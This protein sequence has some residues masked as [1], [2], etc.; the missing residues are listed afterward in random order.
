MKLW[1][2]IYL[3]TIGIF[4]ILLNSGIYL[5]FEMTYHKDI[6]SEQKSAASS[7]N[8]IATD[9]IRN[10]GELDRQG[11]LS[12]IQ[13]HS[14]LEIYENYYSEEAIGLTLW[15]GKTCIYPDEGFPVRAFEVTDTEEQ[16]KI[17][18]Q[19]GQKVIQV[20]GLLYENEE[21]YYLRYE[22]A[23]SEL[24]DTW[25][26]LEKRYLLISI[27]ASAGLAFL[28][29][30][31]L[32]RMMQPIQEL[33]EAVD[34]MSGGN[35]NSRIV[36]RGNDDIAILA[37]HFNE[38]AK[39]LQGDILLMQKEAQAKQMFVDNFAHELKSPLTS[40][41]GFA[42]YIQ[43][44]KVPEQEKTECMGFIMEESTR[45]LNL[46]YTLLD[47]AKMRK[48]D[49]P[50]QEILAEELFAGVR[51]QLEAICEE[52]GVTLHFK[53]D[54][55]MLYGNEILLQSLLYNLVH[56]AA[57]AC[58]KGGEIT[59]TLKTMEETT[60][61]LVED[62]GCGIPQEE[63]EKITEPFY[64]VDKARSR[65]GGRCGLGLSLCRQ[66]VEFHDAELSFSS[67]EGKGTKVMIRFSEKFT[68]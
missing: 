44:A 53:K 20:Q 55:K 49:V 14:L 21:K 10:F 31:V 8:M 29:F 43:K 2:K 3:V 9:L 1:Q 22:K 57:Y 19:E 28:L 32:R 15:Q 63:I 27:G 30:L 48:K 68:V 36:V 18:E 35:L 6:S 50:M 13:I 67:E 56:N 37:G 17:L 51:K 39:K 65:E 58:G 25:D 59:V 24:S 66:I 62:N 41:Y 16:I 11:R 26:R 46:S 60:C 12:K 42:E 47:M 7:Y 5:V 64:R 40:I 4:V 61:L 23:L 52:H 34:E 54:A 38:M 45:L 33:T